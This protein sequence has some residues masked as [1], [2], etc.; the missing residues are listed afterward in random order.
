MRV[1]E[2]IKMYENIFLIEMI[3]I[4]ISENIKG[5]DINNIEIKADKGSVVQTGYDQ[6]ISNVNN[7]I[8]KSNWQDNIFL[9]AIVGV[10]IALVAMSIFWYLT[11]K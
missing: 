11:R 1:K 3:V 4:D 5:P 8:I 7:D 9:Y 10:L 2:T 6:S